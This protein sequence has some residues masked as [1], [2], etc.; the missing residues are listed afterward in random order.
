MLRNIPDTMTAPAIAR[1]DARRSDIG[2]QRGVAILS[3][4]PRAAAAP[5]TSHPRTATKI[6][7]SSEAGQRM[8][9]FLFAVATIPSGSRG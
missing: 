5:G 4:P 9:I 3:L 2:L 6:A 7:A 1:I 8:I